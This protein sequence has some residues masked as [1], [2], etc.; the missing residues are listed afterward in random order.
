MV[1]SQ[2]ENRAKLVLRQSPNTTDTHSPGTAW[3]LDRDDTETAVSSPVNSSWLKGNRPVGHTVVPHLRVEDCSETSVSQ[4]KVKAVDATYDDIRSRG[5]VLGTPLLL[6]RQFLHDN[7]PPYPPF[8]LAT[9]TAAATALH[10]PLSPTQNPPP[11]HI[12]VLILTWA[13]HDRRGAD[14]QLLSP[15]LDGDTEALRACL[16]RRGY[17]VQCRAIPADYPT[18]AVETLLD[19]FLERSTSEGLLVVYY[20]GYGCLDGEGRMV[21]SR[22]APLLCF[23]G[24]CD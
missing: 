4:V 17:R 13:K 22:W 3:F 1:R 5:A 23:A 24:L 6:Q 20:C 18:A 14:G 16:K 21:F 9:A 15:S 10:S 7:Q 12:H 2:P 19:R 11:S 8:S